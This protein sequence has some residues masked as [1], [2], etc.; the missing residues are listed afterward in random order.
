MKTLIF[1]SFK[2]G[3]GRSTAVANL[4]TTLFRLGKSVLVLDL[5]V[6]SPGLPPKL[7]N[8][9]AFHGDRVERAGGIVPYIISLIEHPV[10]W[11]PSRKPPPI[12]PSTIA[13]GDEAARLFLIPTGLVTEKYD[14]LL[15]EDAWHTF[16]RRDKINGNKYLNRR[17]KYLAEITTAVQ[18]LSPPI[19]FML[20][21]LAS[22]M[23][24]LAQ[25]V[26]AAW[27]GPILLFFS[28]DQENIEGTTHILSS[29]H[30][31]EAI[32]HDE[33]LG[34]KDLAVEPYPVLSRLGPFISEERAAVRRQEAAKQL[35]A[36]AEHVLYVRSDPDLEDNWHLHIP[37]S[38]P[39]E[40][41]SLTNDYLRI[42]A[43][44][45]PDLVPAASV[46]QRLQKLRNFL[47][48]PKTIDY[49]YKAFK[50]DE[51]V[52]INLSDDQRN[53]SFKV[54]TFCSILDDFHNNML[55][56]FTP[57]HRGRSIAKVEAEFHRAGF[58]SGQRFAKGLAEL[59]EK[60]GSRADLG[61][62]LQ[63]W[64]QFDSDVGF[65]VL[66]AKLFRR[67][68]TQ[69]WVKIKDNFLAAN[70]TMQH[71]PANLCRLLAGYIAGVLNE[72]TGAQFKVQHPTTHCMRTTTRRL[73]CQFDFKETS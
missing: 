7:I 61:G 47:K 1:Y 67:Q 69:G 15:A 51:G 31:I 45:L 53:V 25:A 32:R 38:G 11:D 50:L 19:D 30:D 58:V 57:T 55:A 8:E 52:L 68:P 23:T 16:A 2:G 35:D 59:W 37:V 73:D 22:G 62:I 21:D 48:L 14:S 42:I 60:R 72:I 43:T 34:R 41:S 33:R 27:A 5:D 28:L 9:S 13:I 70:R 66:S 65:G 63:F 29:I 71:H 20:V 18:E 39:V 64:C 44:I 6:E 12:G 26:F 46:E 56:E 3:Q 36:D 54:N 10:A 4:A 49:H 17:V 40:N 24:P